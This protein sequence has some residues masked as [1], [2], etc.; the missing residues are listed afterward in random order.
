MRAPVY[1]TPE[2]DSFVSFLTEATNEHQQNAFFHLKVTLNRWRDCTS[3]NV[4]TISPTS[5]A[6]MV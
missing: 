4:K 5:R 1:I 2:F 3:T 6:H